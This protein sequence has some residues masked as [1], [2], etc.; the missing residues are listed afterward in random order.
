MTSSR[1]SEIDSIINDVNELENSNISL[2]SQ[3]E[4]KR[5]AIAA[6]AERTS[7]RKRRRSWSS[8]C[9]WTASKEVDEAN[10]NFNF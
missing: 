2:Q 5:S 9:R 4:E 1:N 8:R 10:V 7:Q 6:N 3:L